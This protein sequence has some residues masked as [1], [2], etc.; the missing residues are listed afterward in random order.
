MA[1]FCAGKLS[2]KDAVG[3]REMEKVEKLLLYALLQYC[4]INCGEKFQFLFKLSFL[5]PGRLPAH[6]SSVTENVQRNGP[7]TSAR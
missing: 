2:M 6:S 4:T 3:N 1:Y 7:A 5:V